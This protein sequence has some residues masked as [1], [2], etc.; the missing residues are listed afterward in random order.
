MVIAAW[1]DLDG[2]DECLH[3][4]ASQQG[5][6]SEI[7]VVS[8]APFPPELCARFPWGPLVAGF[9]RRTGSA[10]VEHRYKQQSPENRRDYN[11]AFCASA[12]LAEVYL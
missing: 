4:I 10:F 11:G 9:A 6:A 8:K 2:L 7:L 1:P 5:T 12:R 3:S